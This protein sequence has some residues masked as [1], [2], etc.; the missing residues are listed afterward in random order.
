MQYLSL[1]DFK[2]KEK[3]EILSDISK[4]TDLGISSWTHEAQRLNLGKAIQEQKI[5]NEILKSALDDKEIK[6]VILD[7][8][9]FSKYILLYRKPPYNR[10]QELY[11][12]M[13][14]FKKRIIMQ[15]SFT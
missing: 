10:E 9:L 11:Y 1:I 5:A 15:F 8:M 14:E 2:E 6:S 12:I 4:V 13:M 7:V 3:E